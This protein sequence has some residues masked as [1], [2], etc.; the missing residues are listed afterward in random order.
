[1]SGVIA[2]RYARA[3]MN[4]AVQ[5]DT[6]EAVAGEMDDLADAMLEAPQLSALLA[7]TRVSRAQK[8]EVVAEV[9]KQSGVS[10]LVN[11]FV[12]F[13]A[14]KRRFALLPDIREIFHR[15]ADERLGRA[16]AEVTV[17]APLSGGQERSLQEKLEALSGKQVTLTITVDPEIMGGVI[18]RIGSIVR[19]GSL[20]NQLNQI[21]QSIKEG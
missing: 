5:G 19:D 15:L 2:Q 4:L 13:L 9:L 14:S 11:V 1:M 10:E 3:L 20:R 8:Q 7:D 16:Q 21:R 12:R 6:V 17:A 18:T